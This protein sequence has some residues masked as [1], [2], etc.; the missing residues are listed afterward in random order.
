MNILLDQACVQSLASGVCNGSIYNN[1]ILIIAVYSGDG[2]TG[3]CIKWPNASGQRRRQS[4]A[5][6]FDR[7]WLRTTNVRI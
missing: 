7:A 5:S 4:I 6:D 3:T 1:T 2:I